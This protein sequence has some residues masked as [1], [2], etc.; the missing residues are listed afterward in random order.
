MRFGSVLAFALGL[1]AVPASA[2]PPHGT[3]ETETSAK[4][5]SVK[6]FCRDHRQNSH[7]ET[8]LPGKTFKR[9]DID[10]RDHAF[11]LNG[12]CRFPEKP[13]T[14]FLSG[15]VLRAWDAASPETE[16]A[17]KDA[18]Y[19]QNGWSLYRPPRSW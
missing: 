16:E 3:K 14:V 7:I 4:R 17:V 8:I 2:G 10:H 1:C 12:N 11:T 19:N 6:T 15:C 18:L 9:R 13:S 5:C